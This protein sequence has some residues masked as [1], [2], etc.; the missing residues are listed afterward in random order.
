MDRYEAEV[1]EEV[2][3]SIDKHGAQSDVPLG[4]GHPMYRVREAVA[5][6]ATDLCTAT[7]NLTWLHILMEEV[8]EAMAEENPARVR[9][10]LVQVEAVARRM[11]MVIDETMPEPEPSSVSVDYH[12]PDAPLTDEQ[13]GYR[14][15]GFD[16]PVPTGLPVLQHTHDTDAGGNCRNGLCGYNSEVERAAHGAA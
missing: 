11:R 6:R 3:R 5:K 10:E 4:T 13:I 8:W 15:A 1:R 16:E 14:M 12:R 9:E 7:G 2:D